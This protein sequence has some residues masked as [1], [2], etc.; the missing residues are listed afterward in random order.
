MQN[1]WTGEHAGFG[2]AETGNKPNCCQLCPGSSWEAAG[3][4]AFSLEL[5]QL[6]TALIYFQ[7]LPFTNKRTWI[8]WFSSNN[9]L[10]CISQAITCDWFII[11]STCVIV[12]LM[13]FFTYGSFRSETL[14]VMF[15]NTWEI[16]PFLLLIF[17][18]TSFCSE[19]VVCTMAIIGMSFD[20][21]SV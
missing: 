1:G 11:S 15:L 17:D 19:N 2:S 6:H 16:T 3:E 8:Y 7:T 20:F 5:L 12:F 10:I 21:L 9:R 13:F 18:F 4:K 14:Y